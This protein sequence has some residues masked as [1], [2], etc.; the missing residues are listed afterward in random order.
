MTTQSLP[1]LR[2][3][4]FTAR[5][6]RSLLNLVFVQKDSEGYR[7]FHGVYLPSI[8]T[9]LG[10]ILYLRLGQILGEMGI[11]STLSIIFIATTITLITA[12]SISATATNM[13]VGSG[14]AYYMISRSF[15]IGIGSAVGIPLYCAQAIGTAFYVM[16]FSESV[17]YLFPSIA[18]NTIEFSTLAVVGIV[19][20]ISTNLVMR[21]QFMIFVLVILSLISF[22]CGV[23]LDDISTT[24]T[25]FKSSMGY[26]TAFAIFFPAVTG[27]EAGVSMSGELKNPQRSLPLGAISAVIT[28]LLIYLGATYLLWTRV[29]RQTL[30]EDTMIMQHV[31]MFGPLIL[32]GIWGATSSSALGSMLAGPRTLQAIANDGILPRFIGK[33]FG[34]SGEPRIASVITLGIAA[35]CVYLGD[36]DFIAPILTT[37]FLISY[38][39]LNLA[40]GLESLMNNPSWRP[41]ISVPAALSFLGAGMCIFTMLMIDPGASFTAAFVAI[42]IY[43][44]MS[45]RLTTSW[46]DIRQGVWMYFSRNAIYHLA[47]TTFSARSWRPNVLAFTPHLIPPPIL[48]DF[49]AGVTGKKGF[50]SIAHIFPIEGEK[51]NVEKM[52]SRIK[53]HLVKKEVEA[54]VELVPAQDVTT[55]FQN[56]ISAYGLGPVRPNTIIFGIGEKGLDSD[57]MA[58]AATSAH[59]AN[60]NLVFLKEGKQDKEDVEDKP[61]QIDVWWDEKLRESNDL[62][63]L[64]AHMYSN[65]NSDT[66]IRITLKTVVDNEAA[67]EQRM[68]YL[69]E[70]TAKNRL[71]ISSRVY[72]SNE[73]QHKCIPNFSSDADM[74][75]VGIRAPT[76]F[77]D[78]EEYVTYLSELTK[79]LKNLATTALFLTSERIEVDQIVGRWETK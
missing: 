32:L 29:P 62:M 77:S 30:I 47:E 1:R 6:R 45:R 2:P 20:F 38:G 49:T 63:V 64:F 13:R 78:L 7:T 33:S 76:A 26:W 28:G 11:V 43:A 74:V 79:Q 67:R 75:C 23:T 69:C 14:G 3:K 56:M 16:G 34:K 59:E 24:T 15:G 44:F 70:L 5:M 22:L 4:S 53:E 36:L 73:N 37:F 42:I 41:T 21:M 9:I 18:L 17:H 50:L 57:V 54:L 12:L 55:G 66:P 58:R 8:L 25:T 19:T 31:A 27:V 68:N 35:V 60:K 10:V 39:M 52:K 46:D 65:K 51:L 72:V 71:K 40:A 48:L 61:I